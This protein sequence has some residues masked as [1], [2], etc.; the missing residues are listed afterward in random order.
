[1]QTS[2]TILILTGA[3][4]SAESGLGTFRDSDGLWEQV[5]ITEVATPQAF[6]RDPQKVHDFYNMRRQAAGR[7]QPNATHHALARLQRDWPDPVVL[8]TQNVDALHEAAGSTALHMHGA[9]SGAVCAACDHRWPAPALMAP[10]DACP[11]C[12][13]AATRPDIVWFGEM[14]HHLP[15]IDRHLSDCA[16]FVAIGTSGAVYPAAGFVAEAACHGAATLEINAAA[17]DVSE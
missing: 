14:P 9:L 17:T 1:M 4:I 7:A 12:G 5:P 11:H 6:V 8:I 2:G 3:G 13:K 10:S 15:A 16:L